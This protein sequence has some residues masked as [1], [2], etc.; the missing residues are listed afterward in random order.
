MPAWCFCVGICGNIG[1]SLQ[2]HREFTEPF[3]P[4]ADTAQTLF[5]SNVLGIIVLG[6]H[7]WFWVPQQNDTVPKV[8]Q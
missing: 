5:M 4:A 3:S 2:Q 6:I 7:P 8:R 1:T